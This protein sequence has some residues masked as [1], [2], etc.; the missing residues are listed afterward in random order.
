MLD[1][2]P[3]GKGTIAERLDW[4]I[5][6]RYP[7][8]RGPSAY[9]EISKRSREYAADHPGAPTV[10]HE[11]ARSIHTGRVTNPSVNS[12][13]A[14]ANVYACKVS[15]FLDEE[16]SAAPCE[17]GEPTAPEPPSLAAPQI[18]ARLN[19]LF[20]LMHPKERAECSSQEVADMITAQGCAVTEQQIEGLRQGAGVPVGQEVFGALAAFFRVPVAYLVDKEAPP[21]TAADLAMLSMLQGIGTRSLTLRMVADLD[22]P[23][24][25]ALLPVV[26]HLQSADKHQRMPAEQPSGRAMER[27]PGGSTG[28]GGAERRSL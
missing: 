13:R 28:D 15:Y 18:A 6:N 16:W 2:P 1:N 19:H 3:A 23:S 25:K 10:N 20:G 9:H 26:K 8:G 11:T 24:L 5:R 21:Q 12:L 4:L 17:S 14:L 22:E 27:R 7:G